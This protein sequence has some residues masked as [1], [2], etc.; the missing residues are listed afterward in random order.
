MDDMEE[1]D[2]EETIV[3]KPLIAVGVEGIQT[4]HESAIEAKSA[5][6]MKDEKCSGCGS[7][8]VRRNGVCTICDVC[9]TTGG[10]S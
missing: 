5:G 3:K 4:E 10:C 6:Y 9:G 8:L 2:V 1:P 7:K